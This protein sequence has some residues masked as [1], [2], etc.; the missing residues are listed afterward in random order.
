M[1]NHKTVFMLVCCY[2]LL[3]PVIGVSRS[4]AADTKVPS[5]TAFSN[6]TCDAVFSNTQIKHV[7][8]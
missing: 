7:T 3:N 5:D 4:A 2:I 1:R 6:I 8:F